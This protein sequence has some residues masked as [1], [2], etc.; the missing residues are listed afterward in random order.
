MGDPSHKIVSAN[1][2]NLEEV[3]ACWKKI[4]AKVLWVEAELSEINKWIGK[5]IPKKE[6]L[7]LNAAPLIVGSVELT[8]ENLLIAK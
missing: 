7:N 8:S 6:F 1:L 4:S 3:L 2:Y 5:D